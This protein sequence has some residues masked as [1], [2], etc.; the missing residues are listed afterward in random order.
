MPDALGEDCAAW[1]HPPAELGKQV[2]ANGKDHGNPAE[3]GGESVDHS[4]WGDD[5]HT[6]FEWAEAN[7]GHAVFGQRAGLELWINNLE[8]RDTGCNSGGCPAPAEEAAF[9]PV[10]AEELCWEPQEEED[11]EDGAQNEHDGQWYPVRSNR[12]RCNRGDA[13]GNQVVGRSTG[14]RRGGLTVEVVLGANGVHD[15]ANNQTDNDGH[16]EQRDGNLL[17]GVGD[18]VDDAVG[19]NNGEH[20]EAQVQGDW[21]DGEGLVVALPTDG[22]SSTLEM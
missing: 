12:G 6:D 22:R 15:G 5:G 9:D 10:L 18:Q 7:V 19:D 17:P 13:E 1:R 21:L 4:D 20:D 14:D 11:T 2:N 16:S 8:Q 3:A